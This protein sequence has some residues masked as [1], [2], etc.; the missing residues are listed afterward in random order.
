MED[1]TK[2]LADHVKV[3]M[4]KLAKRL[5]TLF[6]GRL[7]PAHITALSLIGHFPA[8]WALWTGRPVLAAGLIAGFGLLDALDGALARAQGSASKS[9]MFFDAVTD[10]MK[11]IIIYCGLAAYVS[12]YGIGVDHWLIVAVAGSS[13]LV[14]YVK[15]KGEMAVS[16]EKHDKQA[17][18]RAFGSGI[19]RYEVRMAVLIIGLL[20]TIYLGPLLRLLLALNLFTAAGRYFEISR[21]LSIEDADRSK[22]SSPKKE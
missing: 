7:R 2:V 15:A 21:V 13:L 4:S 1:P 17:L 20:F 16:T 8:A 12:G 9:G 10:R 11:E 5:D 18:N 19:S 22:K 3:M 6:K 14:S